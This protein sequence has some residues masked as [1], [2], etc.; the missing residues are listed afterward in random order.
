MSINVLV[1]PPEN[2]EIAVRILSKLVHLADEVVLVGSNRTNYVQLLLDVRSG[3][4]DL[5]LH[6][7]LEAD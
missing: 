7:L 3:L 1:M 4:S 6:L 2:S 5:D